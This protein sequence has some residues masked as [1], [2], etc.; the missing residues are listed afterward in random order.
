MNLWKWRSLW[1]CST[2]FLLTTL[3]LRY[4]DGMFNLSYVFCRVELP[5]IVS[6]RDWVLGEENGFFCQFFPILFYTNS[7]ITLFSLMS[8][9]I[10]RSV[11]NQDFQ[12]CV[13]LTSLYLDGWWSTILTKVNRFSHVEI[14]SW[15]SPFVGCCLQFC[16]CLHWLGFTADMD[17]T[18]KLGECM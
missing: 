13:A 18:V 8:V 1:I 11:K 15:S 2:Y 7:A 10:N 12:K 3:H 5:Y 17:W 16:Y 6:Y 9:T 4:L 14:Q